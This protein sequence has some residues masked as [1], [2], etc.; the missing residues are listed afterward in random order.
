MYLRNTWYVVARSAELGRELMQ[1]WLLNEPYVMY[2][3]EDR[4][5]VALDDRCAHRRYALSKGTLI[6]DNVRCNYHGLVFDPDGACIKIPSQDKVPPQI[7]NRSL[8]LVEKHRWVWAWM[9]EPEK[10]DESLIPDFH[11]MDEPGWTVNEDMRQFD[12]NYRLVVDNLLDLTHETFV[13]AKT[14][15]HEELAEAPIVEARRENGSVKVDRMIGN[16]TPP[17]LFSQAVEFKGNIDRY[18]SVSFEAP[19]F[20]WIDARAVD[21]GSNDLDSGLK[22]EVMNALTPATDTTTHYFWGLSRH[23]AQDDEALTTKLQGA[24]EFTFDE[25]AVVLKIQQ[26]MIESDPPGTL[27][28]NINAD[29]GVTLARRMMDELMENETAQA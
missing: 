20:V 4:R 11:W 22:W 10:A 26:E 5:P 14:I 23:F 27:M 25:D 29:R 3:T 19:C 1:R 17:P 6:G 7:C 15:G 8:P 28:M 12:C 13:H 2:R 24:L 16:C 9:G 18:Q 21:T